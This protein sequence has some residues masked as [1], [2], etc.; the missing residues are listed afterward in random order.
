MAGLFTYTHSYDMCRITYWYGMHV[1]CIAITI[2]IVTTNTSIAWCPNIYG[3]FAITSL[4]KKLRKGY[5]SG[6]HTYIRPIFNGFRLRD[7]SFFILNMRSLGLKTNKKI[8]PKCVSRKIW[9]KALLKIQSRKVGSNRWLVVQDFLFIFLKL[10]R[11][12]SLSD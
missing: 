12:R 3:A 1:W 6:K 4:K 9:N 8:G 7:L 10:V 5:S 2:T 11:S